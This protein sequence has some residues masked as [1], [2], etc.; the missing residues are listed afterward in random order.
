M[1]QV[2]GRPFPPGNTFGRGRPKGSRNKITAQMRRILN[3]ASVSVLAQCILQAQKGHFPSQRLVV[4][5]LRRLQPTRT[6]RSRIKKVADFADLQLAAEQ[7]VLEMFRGDTTSAEAHASMNALE[8]M[9][10]LFDLH[11]QQHKSHRPPKAPMPEFMRSA[12]EAA[13]A[14][15]L[16]AKARAEME[17][18]GTA[19]PPP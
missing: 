1:S 11:A 5:L 17:A 19:P 12:L 14:A 8:Q 13:H 15:R 3:E 2:R 16:E 6:R 4:D 18:A 10:R 7:V 9:G